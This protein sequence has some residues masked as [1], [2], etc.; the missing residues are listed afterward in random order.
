MSSAMKASRRVS[1]VLY[2]DRTAST[3]HNKSL[4]PRFNHPYQLKN[5][6]SRRPRCTKMP[7]PKRKRPSSAFT[8][9]LRTRSLAKAIATSGRWWFRS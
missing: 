2:H 8:P 9:S 1:D 7:A 4:R 6:T 3:L 5:L